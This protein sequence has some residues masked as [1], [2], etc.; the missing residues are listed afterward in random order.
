MSSIIHWPSPRHRLDHRVEEVGIFVEG[1][2][3]GVGGA[4]FLRGAEEEAGLG[5]ADHFKVIVAVAGGDG[6]DSA[7]GLES[8]HGV[9][10]RVPRAKFVAAHVAVG[11]GLDGVREKRRP[12]HLAHQRATEDVEGVGDDYHLGGF[13]KPV[14]KIHRAG[15]GLY[16]VDHSDHLVKRQPVPAQEVDAEAHQLVEV[17]F[18][19]RGA[20]EFGDADLVGEGDPDF[21][22]E[23]ALHVK[24][25][26]VHGL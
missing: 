16:R 15:E 9:E 22:D 20:A 24:A 18:V 21:G 6:V 8:A 1:L 12:A 10:L 23:N 26:Y 2:D 5:G 7:A 4:D 25:D 19:A 14:Q 17:G 13:A 3:V 11:V